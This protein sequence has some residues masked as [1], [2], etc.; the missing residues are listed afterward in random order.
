VAHLDQVLGV[1][2]HDVDVLVRRRDLVDEGGGVAVLDTG[3]RRPQVVSGE[4]R[5]CPRPAAPSVGMTDP[6]VAP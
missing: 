1:L 4:R 6:T 3:H 5:A 2:H